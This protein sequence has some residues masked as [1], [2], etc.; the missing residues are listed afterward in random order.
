VYDSGQHRRC[1][2][3]H[4]FKQNHHEKSHCADDLNSVDAT[5]NLNS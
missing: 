2:G 5:T 3:G 4:P 1:L